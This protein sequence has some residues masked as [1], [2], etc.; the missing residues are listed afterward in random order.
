MK[1]FPRNSGIHASEGFPG[2]CNVFL[3]VAYVIAAA[4]ACLP[5]RGLKYVY[6]NDFGGSC[7]SCSS[8]SF[9]IRVNAYPIE[10]NLNPPSKSHGETFIL[11]FRGNSRTFSNSS[12]FR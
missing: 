11:N 4:D 10:I 12:T 8:A 1:L 2:K 3:V 5:E 9:V 7:S 6:D